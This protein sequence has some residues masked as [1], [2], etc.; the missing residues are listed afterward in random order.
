MR[1]GSLFVVSGPSGTGK[2]SL[3]ERRTQREVLDRVKPTAWII[4]L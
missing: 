1:K 3:V 4:S 2:T